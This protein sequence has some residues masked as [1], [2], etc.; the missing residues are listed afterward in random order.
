MPCSPWTRPALLCNLVLMFGLLTAGCEVGYAFKPLDGERLEG[1]FAVKRRNGVTVTANSVAWQAIQ[2]SYIAVANESTRTWVLRKSNISSRWDPPDGI[3]KS[4]ITSNEEHLRVMRVWPRVVRTK[5]RLFDKLPPPMD[6]IVQWEADHFEIPAGYT[7]LFA[8]S[9]GMWNDDEPR[10]G[11]I[12]LNL[13]LSDGRSK[14]PTLE[15]ELRFRRKGL[16]R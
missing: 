11:T 15:F 7:A 9:K 12:T 16:F 1:S 2:H 10:I 8:Y 3:R 5:D 4:R 6:E 14:P 13:G